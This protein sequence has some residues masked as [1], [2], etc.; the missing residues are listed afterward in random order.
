ML[1]QV[2]TGT[3]TLHWAGQDGQIHQR[4]VLTLTADRGLLPIVLT[5][6][7]CRLQGLTN[8]LNDYTHYIQWHEGHEPEVDKQ[9]LHTGNRQLQSGPI[10]H[11]LNLINMHLQ[12]K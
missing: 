8:S 5:M 12:Y 10:S 11:V 3:Q 6:A 7:D 2:H 4:T 9:S 1:A